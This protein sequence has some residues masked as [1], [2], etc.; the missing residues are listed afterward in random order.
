[1]RI[2]RTAVLVAGFLSS[3]CVSPEPPELADPLDGVWRVTSVTYLMADG[4]VEEPSAQESLFLFDEGFYSMGFAIGDAPSPSFATGLAPTTE[5]LADRAADLTVNAGTY[6]ISGATLTLRP[7]FA[8]M[9]EFVGGYAEIDFA[10]AGDT[11]HLTW[12]RSVSSADIG[13]P[14]TVAGHTE[15]LTLVRLR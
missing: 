7:Q 8:F 1:M 3:A 15:E 12:R 4:V 13:S 10:A 9:P 2:N 6:E 5:E 11:L 14:W